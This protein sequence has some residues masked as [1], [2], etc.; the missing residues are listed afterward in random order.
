MPGLEDYVNVSDAAT[1]LKVHPGTVKR[2]C[3]EHKLSAHKVH[4]GWLIHIDEVRSF[5]KEYKGR[6]GRPSN[7][8]RRGESVGPQQ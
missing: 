3:R 1:I 5:A 4:N 8:R 6:R 2:L 7:S